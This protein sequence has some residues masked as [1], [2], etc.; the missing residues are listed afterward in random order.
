MTKTPVIMKKDITVIA[1]RKMEAPKKTTNDDVFTIIEQP[2]PKVDPKMYT[3]RKILSEWERDIV[4][5]TYHQLLETGSEQAA[6]AI[7]QRLDK[8][9]LQGLRDILVKKIVLSKKTEKDV[10]WL[11]TVAKLTV[12]RENEMLAMNISAANIAL[13]V[14]RAQ[15]EIMKYTIQ[16]SWY[17]I[18]WKNEDYNE[19]QPGYDKIQ[20]I[21][22]TVRKDGDEIGILPFTRKWV[23]KNNEITKDSKTYLITQNDKNILITEEALTSK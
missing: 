4:K 15:G 5:N 22:F 18:Q 17:S 3:S 1:K 12:T 2:D 23:L 19:K 13:E 8:R 21:N 20:S 7:I 16:P 14:K 6:K 11:Q 10:R 9:T